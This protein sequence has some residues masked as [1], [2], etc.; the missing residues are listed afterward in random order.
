MKKYLQNALSDKGLFSRIHKLLSQ[1]NTNSPLCFATCV[2]PGKSPTLSEPLFLHLYGISSPLSWCIIFPRKLFVQSSSVCCLQTGA[3]PR[4][5]TETQCLWLETF[6]AIWQWCSVQAHDLISYLTKALVTMQWK[7][8]KQ[9][10]TLLFLHSQIFHVPA[11][12]QGFPHSSNTWAPACLGTSV[13]VVPLPGMFLPTYGEP[14]ALSVGSRA[15]AAF[16]VRPLCEAGALC[17]LQSPC[18]PAGVVCGL[19]ASSCYVHSIGLLLTIVSLVPGTLRH[20]I[21]AKL[22]HE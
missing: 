2:T 12:L 16:I 9:N 20:A 18:T 5:N 11:S 1:L 22:L 21:L 14:A 6:M 4:W 19:C 15:D 8:K 7:L 17:W 10:L 13:F 3:S